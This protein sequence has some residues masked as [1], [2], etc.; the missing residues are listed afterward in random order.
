MYA[1]TLLILFIS[2]AT[3]VFGEG[4][5]TIYIDKNWSFR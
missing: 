1:D 3:A 5:A 2:V 4:N